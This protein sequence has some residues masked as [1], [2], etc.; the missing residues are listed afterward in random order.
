MNV[1]VRRSLWHAAGRASRWQASRL[2]HSV[3][4]QAPSA[5]ATEEQPIQTRKP[6]VSSKGFNLI[7]AHSLPPPGQPTDNEKAWK[8]PDKLRRKKKKKQSKWWADMDRVSFRLLLTEQMSSSKVSSVLRKYM[9][10]FQI[11]NNNWSD[12]EL[13]MIVCA[14]IKMNRGEMALEVLRN[15]I[16]EPNRDRLNRVAAASARLGNAQV[17]LGVLEITNHFNMVPDV[18]TFTSAIHACA[19]GGKYDPPMALNLLNEMISVGVEPNA[20]TYGAA[21]LA[22][23]RMMRWEEI[24]EMVSSI[25][26]KD[27]AHKREVFTCAIVSCSRNRQHNYASRLFEL[28]LEDGV[29]P[30]DNVCNAALSACAR[31]SDLTQLR[32]IY[33]LVERHTTPSVYSF[34]CMISA[35]GNACKLDEALQVFETMRNE[36]TVAPDVVTFNSLLLAAVRSRNVDM[37]P[38]ILSAMSEAGLKW[39]AYTLNI[40]LEGCALNGD[41]EMARHYWAE[42]T[43][44]SQLGSDES[45]EGKQNV[46]LDRAHYETLM[47]VYFAAKDYKELVDLWQNDKLCRRRAKSSKALNFLIRACEGLKDDTTAVAIL[48]QFADRGQSLSS[49]THHHMLE[50]FLA[51]DK[52][53]AASAYLHKML[54]VDGLVSTF[55]FTVLIKYLAKNKRHSDVLALFDLYLKTRDTSCKGQ[56][57]L[58]HY[59]T[60]A[61]YVLTMRS[62]VELQDHETVLAIY[63]DLPTTMS[64]AVRTELLVLAISSCECEGDW[65]AAVTMYDEMTGKLDE[66]TNVELYKHIV[67]IVASAGEFDRALDVGGGQWYRQNRPDKG[68]GLS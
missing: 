7:S 44:G 39:D 41:S 43:Q 29:Y 62:A 61:I 11:L 28:L 63:G 51:A 20:R 19:R 57:P 60:D 21:I 42:A 38:F 8:R 1:T 48:A 9:D 36:S 53:N 37:F 30:G 14:L 12:Q 26:Y 27:D 54:K 49:I 34:N 59:P 66:D 33:K 65:R 3:A 18:V 17:A 6:T 50:V 45:P 46:T 2:T 31:T 16:T 47:G 67:K 64:M 25:S 5:D 4:S 10:E 32:R 22:L 58:L 23:A 40:L 56:N 55:S 15:Q 13:V 24:E 68:W 35:F 52:Y